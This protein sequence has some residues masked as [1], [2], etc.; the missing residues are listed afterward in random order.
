MIPYRSYDLRV[1]H[2]AGVAALLMLA[3][4]LAGCSH[5]DSGDDATMGATSAATDLL[6]PRLTVGGLGF[7]RARYPLAVGNRWDY[8]LSGTH[9]VITDAGPQPPMT[10]VETQRVEIVGTERIGEHEYFVREVSFPQSGSPYSEYVYMREDRSGVFILPTEG[11]YVGSPGAGAVGPRF[12]R[13]LGAYVDRTVLDP[14]RRDDFQR[15]VASMVVKLAAGRP[16]IGV[17]SAKAQRAEPGETTEL[18]FPLFV[19]AHWSVFEGSGFVRS[20]VGRERIRVP[21]GAFSAWRVRETSNLLGPA[22][23]SYLWYGAVG[24]V[25]ERY[26]Y[27]VAATDTSGHTVGRVLIDTEVSLTAIHLEDG[28]ATPGLGAGN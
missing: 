9:Q 18:R 14:G 2:A 11:G 12:V 10:F 24:W 1:V 19:G 28:A 7:A 5:K 17:E 27:E 25:H 15:A 26:H 20:V 4:G 23:R 13:Q 21:L 8:R 6:A 16:T 22:D 3:T